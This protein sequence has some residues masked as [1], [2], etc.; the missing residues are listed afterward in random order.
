M[1][2]GKQIICKRF[3]TNRKAM[4]V[5]GF[6]AMRRGVA[7]RVEQLAARGAWA[8]RT[9]SG[10]MLMRGDIFAAS[11]GGGAG[12][13][14]GSDPPMGWWL[15]LHQPGVLGSIPKREEPGKTGT[16]SVS[17]H[18]TTIVGGSGE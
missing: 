12:C 3:A 15:G 11:P 9:G 7:G 17:I 13:W 16:P 1:T 6:T 14:L 10:P 2:A 8:A 18:F 4:C 5:G